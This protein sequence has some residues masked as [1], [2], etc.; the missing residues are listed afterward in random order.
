MDP[1]LIETIEKNKREA[2]DLS[3]QDPYYAKKAIW[4][5]RSATYQLIISG[6]IEE[7]HHLQS[8]ILKEI[9][10]HLFP[11]DQTWALG[12]CSETWFKAALNLPYSNK[13]ICIRR[14]FCL[15]SLAIK[16]GKNIQGYSARAFQ[17]SNSVMYLIHLCKIIDE[18]DFKKDHFRIT[19]CNLKVKRW[20]D[21]AIKFSDKT[22]ENS[23]KAV[24]QAED[25]NLRS[26]LSLIRAYI[27]KGLLLKRLGTDFRIMGELTAEKKAFDEF[28][29]AEKIINGLLYPKEKRENIYQYQNRECNGMIVVQ[30]KVYFSDDKDVKEM[31]K[32]RALVLKNL[33][34]A[35]SRLGK[36]EKGQGYLLGAQAIFYDN[37]EVEDAFE[38]YIDLALVEQNYDPLSALT[39]IEYLKALSSVRPESSLVKRLRG[40]RLIIDRLDRE[41]L[42]DS[43][44]LHGEKISTEE[45]LIR[46]KESIR[47]EQPIGIVANLKKLVKFL[48]G[49]EKPQ[50]LNFFNRLFRKKKLL[51]RIFLLLNK[52]AIFSAQ[53]YLSGNFL[54]GEQ[55]LEN[56]SITLSENSDY[57]L[58]CLDLAFKIAERYIPAKLPE[59]L[60]DKYHIAKSDEERREILFQAVAVVS[61]GSLNYTAISIFNE[62]LKMFSGDDQLKV[63]KNIL[64]LFKNSIEQ[65]PFCEKKFRI[66]QKFME[67]NKEI[68]K[69]VLEG[70][71]DPNWLFLAAEIDEARRLLD[72]RLGIPESFRHIKNTYVN[73]LKDVIEKKTSNK[74]SWESLIEDVVVEQAPDLLSQEKE[75]ICSDIKGEKMNLRVLGGEEV[76]RDTYK[77]QKILKDTFPSKRVGLV[78][79]LNSS[80]EVAAIVITAEKVEV[81]RMELPFE[82]ERLIKG[83]WEDLSRPEKTVH[84]SLKIASILVK[85]LPTKEVD[86]LYMV[87]SASLA[88][89]P[90]HALK[91]TP[92]SP[93][94]IYQCEIAYSLSAC[95]LMHLLKKPL[96]KNKNILLLGWQKEIEAQNHLNEVIAELNLQPSGVY[97]TDPKSG[98]EVLTQENEY[99]LIYAFGH[100]HTRG[101]LKAYLE[102]GDDQ[103]ISAE[104]FL[105]N[106]GSKAGF[107][108]LNS[109]DLARGE[110]I[111]GDIYGMGFGILGGANSSCLL[112]ARPICRDTASLFGK[113]VLRKIFEGSA[114]ST[115]FREAVKLSTNSHPFFWA[116]YFLYGDIRNPYI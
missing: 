17:F 73:N 12:E 51:E 91:P 114:I 111:D 79:Y 11:N 45:I 71:R 6:E 1:N 43:Q 116:P 92:D 22:I 5:L 77:V 20:I 101:G 16:K 7:A 94:L 82:P 2:R 81:K 68:K 47:R 46:I 48:Q 33:G 35:L 39:R 30:G 58:I 32:Q 60:L 14:A 28:I 3:N 31:E 42:G 67:Y 57:V 85:D 9:I 41:V 53:D 52:V 59:I 56:T 15:M 76:L 110:V 90:F 44:E 109:C 62:A 18:S 25:G 80:R 64:T 88:G 34:T 40:I 87:P 21:L 54:T 27:N 102:L 37:Y 65:L 105:I 36:Q 66:I 63:A 10:P 13:L 107:V 113:I 89:L 19:P 108:F 98:I 75:R 29:K 24:R 61:L 72:L 112:A 99:G 4:P 100:G 103:K 93:Y 26:K 50:N 95:L 115:A 78:R 8:W 96:R 83:C 86:T 97:P 74:Y 38:N 84:N 23:E 104:D 69:I 55:V 106:F 70:E 49:V